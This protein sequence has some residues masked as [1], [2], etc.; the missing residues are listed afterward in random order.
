MLTKVQKWGNSQGLRVTKDVLAEADI[1]VG[2]AVNV[3]ARGG[4]IIIEPVKKVRGRYD[5]KQ[6]I[7]KI[8]KD[9]LAEE[10]DWGTPAGKEVW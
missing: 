5:L 3:S 10:V 4:K 6:L 2:D 7:A 1:E 8:P 9:Y